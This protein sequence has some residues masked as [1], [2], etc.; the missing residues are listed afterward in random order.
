MAKE[1]C[2]NCRREGRGIY[3]VQCAEQDVSRHNRANARL[4]RRAKRGK[5]DVLHPFYR[6]MDGD[7]SEMCIILNIAMTGEMFGRC[8]HPFS[9][10]AA[11]H[12]R[13]KIADQYRVVAE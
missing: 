10:N 5:L 4:N 11:N 6:M 13:P 8:D 1:R 7:G 3:C 12:R 9:L 2:Q